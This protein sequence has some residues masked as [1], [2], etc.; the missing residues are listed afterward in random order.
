MKIGEETYKNLVDISNNEHQMFNRKKSKLEYINDELNEFIND[1]GFIK[2]GFITRL[3]LY[4]FFNP[5]YN[6]FSVLYKHKVYE[7]ELKIKGKESSDI[8]SFKIILLIFDETVRLVLYSPDINKKILDTKKYSY[9][10]KL[11]E[12][13]SLCYAVYSYF[14]IKEHPHSSSDIQSTINI[15]I[16][17]LSEELKHSLINR[18]EG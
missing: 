17:E 10:K 9:I 1:N 7:K 5:N 15:Y 2:V 6:S 16:K 8:N 13:F 14:C 12:R 4:L 18:M 3:R 11:Y